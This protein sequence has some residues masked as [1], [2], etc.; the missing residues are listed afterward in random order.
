[1]SR[2]ARENDRAER[3][4][5]IMERVQRGE[6]TKLAAHISLKSDATQTLYFTRRQKLSTEILIP[7]GLF[8]FRIPISEIVE[9]EHHFYLFSSDVSHVTHYSAMCCNFQF[10]A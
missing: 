4:A 5:R 7:F 2:R 8:C 1:M 3:E 10:A 9:T 6:R